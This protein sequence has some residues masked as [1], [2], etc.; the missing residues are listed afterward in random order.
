[1]LENIGQFFRGYLPL[2]I[3]MYLCLYVEGKNVRNTPDWMMPYL[4]SEYLPSTEYGRILGAI[5]HL[6]E[7]A[8]TTFPNMKQC[9]LVTGMTV[10]I[11]RVEQYLEVTKSQVC[12]EPQD[13]SRG[14]QHPGVRVT[15][16][17]S[18]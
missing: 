9:F 3:A 15:L 11:G 8:I 10:P 2:T 4:I 7:H 16:S 1:M 14:V 17:D 6:F 5:V 18:R 12:F 13:E